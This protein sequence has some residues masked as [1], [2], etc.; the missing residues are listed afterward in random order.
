MIEFR[1]SLT[2]SYM[3]K[4]F[5]QVRFSMPQP[6]R[7]N[8]TV[9]QVASDIPDLAPLVPASERS[10]IAPFVRPLSHGEQVFQVA[11]A[12]VRRSPHSG[13]RRLIAV[14]VG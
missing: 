9:W 8:G 1:R 3:F 12:C 6:R 4:F 10:A 14:C 7:A 2:T 11:E 13:I 5:L